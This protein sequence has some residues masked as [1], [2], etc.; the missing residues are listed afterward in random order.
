MKAK[1]KVLALV[2][3]LTFALTLCPISGFAAGTVDGLIIDDVTGCQVATAITT[4]LSLPAGYTWSSSD[5]SII[6]IGAEADG[7]IPATVTRKNGVDQPVTLTASDGATTKDFDL[8]VL[9][10]ETKVI[11]AGTSAGGQQDVLTKFTKEASNFI[12]ENATQTLT[13]A[14]EANGNYYQNYNFRNT[15]GYDVNELTVDE[16]SLV[17]GAES[18]VIEFDFNYNQTLSNPVDLI[19]SMP[20]MKN[21]RLARWRGDVT[22]IYFGN[23]SNGAY[24]SYVSGWNH[25]KIELNM[26]TGAVA[27][28]ITNAN[29]TVSKTSNC[30][31]TTY[32][33]QNFFD[34]SAVGVRRV[35]LA[36]GSSSA[37]CGVF[38]LDNFAVYAKLPSELSAADQK[39]YI[40]SLNWSDYSNEDASSITTLSEIFGTDGG[41]INW[42]SDNSAITFA[43]VKYTTTDESVSKIVG[44]T[45]TVTRPDGKL[46]TNV[47]ITA[48]HKD[49]AEYGEKKFNVSVLPNNYSTD[50]NS[51]SSTV[52]QIVED[53]ENGTADEN[54]AFAADEDFRG[55]GVSSW[56][57]T[58]A[59]QFKYILDSDKGMVASLSGGDKRMLIKSGASG[60]TF[61][62]ATVGMEIKFT[63]GETAASYSRFRFYC[64]YP[65]ADVYIKNGQ[66][67]IGLNNSSSPERVWYD[68]DTSDWMRIDIDTN[69]TSRTNDIYVNG[70]KLNS[71][72]LTNWTYYATGNVEN[73]VR[74]IRFDTN[75]TS[76][77]LLDNISVTC[78]T[79]ADKTKA[80]A[81]INA[82]TVYFNEDTVTSALTLPVTGPKFASTVD[83]VNNGISMDGGATIAWTEN[84]EA[85]TSLN[86]TSPME[87]NYTLT[88]TSGTE[89]ATGSV[90]IKG[91]P[92]I[93]SVDEEGNVSLEGNTDGGT[94]I[95]ATMDGDKLATVKAYTSF[96]GISVSNIESYKLIF[97]DS[98]ANLAP[99]AFSI[100]K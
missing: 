58:N 68:V 6:A 84:G 89:T 50:F 32:T 31:N 49:G 87:H 28:T 78:A 85:V 12:D 51:N 66:I 36:K 92:V 20:T 60:N 17:N 93:I 74:T 14:Q 45:A 27:G 57:S 63:S 72:P 41:F 40:E 33:A 18:V 7:V 5:D 37:D 76:E 9:A 48:T 97:I 25:V 26:Y 95:V 55:T 29:G 11:A 71:V 47:V 4:D 61:N 77:I 39:E 22:R 15:K 2:M 35:F 83:F 54:V 3:M 64:A 23:E 73:L 70:V 81:A 91:T 16:I 21:V 52:C 96:D 8:V 65:I 56:G 53:F 94:L 24:T 10:K 13:I 59:G 99:L 67:G 62:S 44:K 42:S 69:F 19:L 88:A 100:S 46:N 75:G 82:A 79:N 30:F 86:P 1:T 38:A 80:E 90:K 98:F 34:D 43:D